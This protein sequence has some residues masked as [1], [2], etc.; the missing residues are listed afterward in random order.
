MGRTDG[1]KARMRAKCQSM[2]C[3]LEWLQLLNVLHL[4]FCLS[5]LSSLLLMIDSPQKSS[6]GWQPERRRRR[7]NIKTTEQRGRR[8]GQ[9]NRYC[10]NT[11]CKRRSFRSS[12]QSRFRATATKATGKIALKKK[13]KQK[14]YF[15]LVLGDETVAQ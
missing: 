10:Q 5:H 3:L 7:M 11:N 8:R 2:V 15:W 6:G 1:I 12:L 9:M 13:K 14:L 4:L